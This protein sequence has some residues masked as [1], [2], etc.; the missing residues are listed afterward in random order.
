MLYHQNGTPL[1]LADHIRDLMKVANRILNKIDC[2]IPNIPL[3]LFALY[4]VSLAALEEQLCLDT[5]DMRHAI[6][7]HEAASKFNNRVL[8]RPCF[9]EFTRV[10]PSQ[11]QVSSSTRADSAA[12]T[13]FAT[14][15]LSRS[16]ALGMPFSITKVCTTSRIIPSRSVVPPCG[17][18]TPPS[19]RGATVMTTP[20]T[21]SSSPRSLDACPDPLT[22]FIP[23][24]RSMT[25][26]TYTPF[27]SIDLIIRSID[28]TT[29]S[30]DI[31]YGIMDLCPLS[32]PLS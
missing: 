12:G 29:R 22:S 17:V 7:L 23:L 1:P 9:L 24:A 10:Q 11:Y 31:V 6:L 32:S 14:D 27:R 21:T 19:R 16:K 4:D 8:G 18:E 26:F 28:I 5:F 30:V 25:S 3:H 2:E 20:Y 13:T 15:S